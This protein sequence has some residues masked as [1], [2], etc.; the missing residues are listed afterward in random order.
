MGAKLRPKFLQNLEFARKST[1]GSY[2]EVLPLARKLQENQ[3]PG[4]NPQVEIAVPSKQKR[5]VGDIDILTVTDHPD[6]VMDFFT[7]MDLLMR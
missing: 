3:C 4:R 5:N 6:E 1:E 7:H 2:W